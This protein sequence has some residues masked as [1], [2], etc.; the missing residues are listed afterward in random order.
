MQRVAACCSVLQSV[1]MC[2]NVLQ[3]VNMSLS[4]PKPRLLR[5]LLCVSVPYSLLQGVAVGCSGLQHVSARD[6]IL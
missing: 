6:I 3:C 5:R 1:A 4:A 2:C